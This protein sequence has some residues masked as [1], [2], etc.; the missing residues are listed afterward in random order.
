MCLLAW[1]QLRLAEDT[2]WEDRF[3]TRLPRGVWRFLACLAAQGLHPAL[4]QKNL[5][6]FKDLRNT[7][8]WATSV[9]MA[10]RASNSAEC[11]HQVGSGMT[12]PCTSDGQVPPR[13][14]GPGP[15][16]CFLK[17]GT[18]LPPA[19]T[20]L[21]TIRVFAAVSTRGI[22]RPWLPELH[23][24]VCLASYL[25]LES[26]HHINEMRVYVLLCRAQCWVW[27][28]GPAGAV[29]GMCPSAHWPHSQLVR[30]G[31]ERNHAG[32]VAKQHREVLVRDH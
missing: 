20:P 6:L 9:Q 18:R 19:L 14:R 28:G 22:G 12:A 1:F 11:P 27:R 7:A 5:L 13:T 17:S 4:S 24:D 23:G 32:L 26:S 30:I 15:G 21:V 3:G 31:L 8:R 10:F 25:L 29:P 2:C 16:C